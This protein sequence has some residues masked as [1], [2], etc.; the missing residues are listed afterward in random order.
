[1]R[2]EPSDIL[3]RWCLRVTVRDDGGNGFVLTAYRVRFRKEYN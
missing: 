3:D 1:M 2:G